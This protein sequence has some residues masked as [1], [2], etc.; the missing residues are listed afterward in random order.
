MKSRSL[1]NLTVFNR[2][3]KEWNVVV[4]TPRGSQYKY[5]YDPAHDVFNLHCMLPEGMSFP[6]EFGFLPQTLGSDGDPLD[7]L[8]IIRDATF[9]GC[10]IPCRIVGVIEANQPEKDGTQEPNDRLV[11]IPAISREE[12]DI[13]SLKQLNPHILEEIE[14]FFAGYDRVLGKEFKV[15]GIRGP[16]VAGKLINEGMRRFRK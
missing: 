11:A 8:V 14:A 7:V 2:K 4:E 13:K 10:V 12:S 5:K 3:T 15:L 1:E 6:Y 16:K 9:S